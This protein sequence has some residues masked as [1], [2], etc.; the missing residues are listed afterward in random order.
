M[1]PPYW[2]S[3]MEIPGLDVYYPWMPPYPPLNPA[4]GTWTYRS[5]MN[6]P[7]ISKDFND[8]EFG[9][10][11]LIIEQLAPGI[12]EGR[13][14]FGD[15]YQFRLRGVADLRP[16]PCTVVRFQ[17]VGDTRDSKGQVYDYMGFF[18]P[19]WSNG[20]DQRPALVGSTV[21]TVAHNGD[22]ARAGVVGTFIALKRDEEAQ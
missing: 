11:D 5:F 15:T 17:G 10:G 14:S 2:P 3:H 1:S 12:F 13:L 20:M 8:L 6:N 16:F 18:V 4:L 9:R 22:R 7:D 21:R 19:M